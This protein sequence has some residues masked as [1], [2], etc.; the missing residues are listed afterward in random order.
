MDDRV[1]EFIG[2]AMSALKT[3]PPDIKTALLFI[4]LADGDVQL[5]KRRISKL[6]R[7]IA[8]DEEAEVI[9]ITH[10]HLQE[11]EPDVLIG[12]YG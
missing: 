9:V 1:F 4:E 11:N 10:P 12:K 5:L 7:V 2:N 6:E 3:K 8:G